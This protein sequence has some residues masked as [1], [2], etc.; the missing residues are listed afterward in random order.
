MVSSLT[1]ITGKSTLLSVEPV[2]NGRIFTK[3]IK[4]PKPKCL[5]SRLL[6]DRKTYRKVGN[7]YVMR[8]PII[9][10]RNQEGQDEPV[11]LI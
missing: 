6:T 1:D 10:K 8:S 9:T 2:Q 11:S 3:R 4:S 5:I 7:L